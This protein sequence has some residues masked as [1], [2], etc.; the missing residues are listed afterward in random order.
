MTSAQNR[1]RRTRH[2]N[3]VI[4]RALL[5]PTDAQLRE[6]VRLRTTT[7]VPDLAERVRRRGALL[8]RRQRA[9]RVEIQ[10]ARD[11]FILALYADAT[12]AGWHTAWCDGSVAAER[13][14]GAGIGGLV[15][16][17]EGRIVAQLARRVPDLAPFEAEIAALAETL[18]AA[19]AQGAQRLRVHTDCDALVR[20]WQRR[21]DDP[22]LQA[23]ATLAKGFRRMELRALPRL[24]N[25][26]AHRLAKTGA[27]HERA[28]ADIE[29][30]DGAERAGGAG[31]VVP[32]DP[33]GRRILHVDMDAFF[34]AIELQRHPE[35]SGRP[36]IIGGRGD[37]RERGVVSTASYEARRFGVY[38]GMPLR[39]A[40][41]RCPQAVFL[42]V[43]YETYAA[44]SARIKRILAAFTPNLEDAGIDEAFLDI[45]AIPGPAED[46]ARAIKQRIREDTGLTCSVGIAPNKL[47][48]KM[49]SDLEKPDG[50]TILGEGDIKKRLWPLPVR[51]LWGVGPK[52]E[53]RLAGLGIATIGQLAQTPAAALVAQFGPAHGRTLRQS[54]RGIDDSPLITHWEPKS[55]GRETTFQRDTGDWTRI[56]AALLALT[57]ELVA[58]M[59]TERYLARNVTVKLRF[60]D[61]DTHTHAVTLAAATDDPEPVTHA[62][63][64][65][66]KRFA[67]IKKVRLIGV[68]LGGLTHAEAAPNV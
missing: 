5:Q 17:P 54:A 6:A 19:R 20:A 21:R 13:R 23:I 45:S 58:H 8:A 41:R 47:L 7:S 27:P 50:L 38:S 46:V 63:L 18:R 29:P 57:R 48:A 36:L 15:M 64:Q 39:T 66:L 24:H 68:R 12:P 32:V 35:L 61:F 34:A 40:L 11:D 30:A 56:R 9:Q 60:A 51:K 53:Q 44:V 37:P 3:D 2:V 42:P 1:Q 33:A 67:L 59:Q 65:C 55:L 52:T 4:D 10:R 31:R 16:D 49:A 14:A 22:R 28:R 26:P 43:D 62:V 25:Q